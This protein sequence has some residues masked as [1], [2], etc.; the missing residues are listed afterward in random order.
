VQ[1]IP[2]FRITHTLPSGTPLQGQQINAR[3]ADGVV[4]P[5][6]VFGPAD[7]PTRLVCSHGNGMAVDGYVDFWAQLA[8]DFQVVVLDFR[9]HG[10][11][12]AGP[13][14][15]HNWEWFRRDLGMVLQI[16]NRTLGR[17]HTVGAFHSLSSI[18]SLHYVRE[19]GA[20]L[21]ALVL[22]DPPFM[23]PQGHPH[24]HAHMAEM[25]GLAQRATLRRS[26]FNDPLEL[27]AQFAKQPHCSRW[28]PHVHETMARA[29]MHPD[30][31]SEPQNS[32]DSRGWRLSCAPDREGHV[33]ASNDDASL[34]EYLAKV[35]IPLLIVASDP[36]VQG[37]SVSAR[38][39]L[40]AARHYGVRYQCVPDTTHFLQLERPDLCARALRDF[41]RTLP[42][43]VEGG[44]VTDTAAA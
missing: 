12:G 36:D 44:D 41:V 7:A 20:D 1:T 8:D 33:F 37:V 14:A 28:Q 42:V 13:Y 26:H 19:Q 34:Y 27:A 21:D 22:F 23:P 38:A 9:G 32:T 18:V 29:V 39:C 2:L 16:L 40:W 24:R 5:L 17:R 6:R 15:H 3:M 4:I 11:S 25:Y 35:R 31:V 30:P 43:G 10:R